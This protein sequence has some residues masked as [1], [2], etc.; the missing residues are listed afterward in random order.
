MAENSI[1]VKNIIKKAFTNLEDNCELCN[2]NSK[3][4]EHLMQQALSFTDYVS[5]RTMVLI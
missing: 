5:H 3:T 2:Q 1:P 4:L